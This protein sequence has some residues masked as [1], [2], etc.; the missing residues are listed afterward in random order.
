MR[1]WMRWQ[2]R[3]VK[4]WFQRAN[5]GWADHDTW[6]F[7][8]YLAGVMAGGLRHL[9]KHA[10][11]YPDGFP[12]GAEGWEA[13]LRDKAEWFEWYQDWQVNDD[14]AKL[15]KFYNEVLPDLVK[16]YEGLWD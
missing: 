14:I 3:R 4:G 10:H 5:R 12:G 6:S 16:W 13:W 15:H 2:Y 11:G 7:D 9:A 8:W 1:G